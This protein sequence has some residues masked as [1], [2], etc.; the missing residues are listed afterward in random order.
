M[1]SDIFSNFSP[2]LSQKRGYQVWT[3]PPAFVSAIISAL[4][5]KQSSKEF[6]SG[7]ASATVGKWDIWLEFCRDMGL[8]PF[9]EAFQDKIPILQVFSHQVCLGELAV[10][11][12]DIKS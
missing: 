4:L 1:R 12:N 5:R 9:L 8:D 2:Y 6:F 3:P 7:R 11:G 10:K